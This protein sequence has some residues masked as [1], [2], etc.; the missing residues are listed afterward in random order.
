MINLGKEKAMFKKVVSTGLS[1]MMV[2]GLVCN[3]STVL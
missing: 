3:Q 2:F 1:A